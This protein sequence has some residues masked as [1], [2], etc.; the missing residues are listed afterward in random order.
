MNTEQP[1][2]T[3]K[4][5]GSQS[6]LYASSAPETRMRDKRH[7]ATCGYQRINATKGECDCGYF[8]LPD[9]EQRTIP[10][11]KLTDDVP[12]DSSDGFEREDGSETQHGS[13]ESER[14]SYKAHADALA[15]ALRKL[16][17]SIGSGHEYEAVIQA[18]QALAA[19]EES[20]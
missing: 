2:T 10:A 6:E 20:K 15:E 11:E 12:D 16:H 13:V 14:D 3:A 4:A 7:T 1:T 19:Y 9:A 5:R 18:K 17:L 8:N